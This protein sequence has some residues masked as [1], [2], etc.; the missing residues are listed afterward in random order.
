MTD[1]APVIQ[2][3]DAG[4]RFKRN[5]RSHRSFKDLFAGSKRRSRPDEFWPLRHV[6][7]SVAPGESDATARA[8]P[9]CSSSSPRWC[10]PTKGT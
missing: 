6:S 3:T 8:S 9:P 5:R 2:V 1:T 7:F 4:I 10:S